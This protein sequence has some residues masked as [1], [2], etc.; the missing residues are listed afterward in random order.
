MRQPRDHAIMKH[1]IISTA[2][3]L[4]IAATASANFAPPP[5]PLVRGPR[6]A[7]LVI[8][9]DE[10]ARV[11]RLEI[12]EKLLAAQAAQ[13][14]EKRGDAGPQLPMTVAGV[15]LAGAFVS[16]GLWLTR[17]NRTVA[18]VAMAFLLVGGAAIADVGVKPRPAPKPTGVTLPANLKIASDKLTLVVTREG[19]DTVT[20]IVPKG[21][22]EAEAKPE[23]KP[24]RGE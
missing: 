9:V 23:T 2:G 15:A 17:R 8:E 19:G 10:Q 3:L 14:G 11:P 4:L 7:K 6:P 18:G 13:P 1:A 20:L 5:P 12:P 22:V 21:M 24:N 16:G